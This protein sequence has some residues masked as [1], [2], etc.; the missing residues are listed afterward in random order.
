MREMV[1]TFRLQIPNAI[2]L[3]NSNLTGLAGDLAYPGNRDTIYCLRQTR[4]LSGRDSKQQFEVFAV[5]YVGR[6]NEPERLLVRSKAARVLP[7]Q[8]R[9]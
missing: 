3:G 4:H 9:G 2:F 8:H 5:V 6:H 7:S 1:K